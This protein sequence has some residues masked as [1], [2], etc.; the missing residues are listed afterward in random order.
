SRRSWRGRRAG[1]RRFDIN[2]A[3]FAA[4][5]PSSSYDSSSR[6]EFR[7]AMNA[8]SLRT[9]VVEDEPLVRLMTEDILIAV[10]CTIAATASS[11]SEEL[12]HIAAT[13]FDLA[14]LDINL[15]GTE[16]Y[17]AAELLHRKGTPIVF[18]TGYGR[19]GVQQAW[20]A[21]QILQKPFSLPDLERAIAL[22]RG[23]S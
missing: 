5:C 21:F 22:A 2:R 18:V 12:N 3:G 16:V 4:T 13:Q 20:Q 7:P 8:V 14:V 23:P 17:P 19:R 6:C 10:G 11:L 9:I 15:A 1:L